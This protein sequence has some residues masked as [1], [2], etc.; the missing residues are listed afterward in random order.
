MAA[1]ATLARRGGGSGALSSPTMATKMSG[2]DD[3]ASIG[4]GGGGGGN[5]GS[6]GTKLTADAAT[7]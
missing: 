4:S 2:V 5:G 1:T 6:S 3:A 7:W